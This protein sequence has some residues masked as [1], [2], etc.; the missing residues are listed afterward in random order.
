M[1]EENK[2]ERAAAIWVAERFHLDADKVT[3]VTFSNYYGGGCETCGYETLGI[4]FHYNGK[5]RD[6]ELGYYSITPG[7]F[8]QECVEILDRDA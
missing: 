6:E 7:Q 3:G 2:F 4:E 8:L 1:T 5:L